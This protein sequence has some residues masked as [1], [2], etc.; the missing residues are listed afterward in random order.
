LLTNGSKCTT[1]GACS[2]G[3]CVDGVCCDKACAKCNACSQNLTGK[4]DG[5]CAPATS[6][7]DPHESCADETDANECG[8]DGNCDGSG[9]CR[10]VGNRSSVHGQ[11]LQRQ[12]LHTCV[13]LR[14]GWRVQD[15]D[16]GK[17][18]GIQCSD[19]DGCKKNLLRTS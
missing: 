11:P 9:A 5:T 2:S 3:F 14:R 15:R 10:K 17:L 12:Y 13:E 7:T 1:A 8:N 19:T 16:P 18:R 6:G 4:A